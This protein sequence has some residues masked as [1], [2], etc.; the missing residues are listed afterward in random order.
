[1]QQVC[2]D[3]HGVV[4]EFLLTDTVCIFAASFMHTGVDQLHEIHA[5]FSYDGQYDDQSV[6]LGAAD[7]WR[8]AR[9]RDCVL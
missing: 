8:K 9:D 5:A 3:V 4:R 6:K 7:L 1:M 2:C